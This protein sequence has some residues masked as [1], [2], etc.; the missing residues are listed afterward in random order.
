MRVRSLVLLLA[1]VISSFV[2]DIGSTSGTL[3]AFFLRPAI[4]GFLVATLWWK[5]AFL[6]RMIL[7]AVTVF[8]SLAWSMM[9]YAMQTD[10]SNILKDSPTQAM[11]IYES[12]WT[13][14]LAW[15]VC[16][17]SVITRRKGTEQHDADNQ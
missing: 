11:M 4:L 16:E 12:I 7:G 10:W 1:A 2:W 5:Q 3:I 17:G 14:I 8:A 9:V 15:V 6:K 13:I